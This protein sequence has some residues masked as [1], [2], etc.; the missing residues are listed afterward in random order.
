ML[1]MPR[2]QIG[3]WNVHSTVYKQ[4]DLQQKCPRNVLPQTGE[5]LVLPADLSSTSGQDCFA[6]SRP[7]QNTR[8]RLVAITTHMYKCARHACA[9]A[10]EHTCHVHKQRT[11]IGRNVHTQCDAAVHVVLPAW[12]QFAIK[13]TDIEDREDTAVIVT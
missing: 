2:K 7:S 10:L 11:V 6:T 9:R 4:V 3:L 8:R 5:S 1:T 13:A 12:R